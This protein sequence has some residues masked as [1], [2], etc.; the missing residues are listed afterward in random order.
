[1]ASR[2]FVPVV[3]VVGVGPGSARHVYLPLSY[4]IFGSLHTSRIFSYLQAAC[5][6]VAQFMVSVLFSGDDLFCACFRRTRLMLCSWL[7][8]TLFNG[9]WV[10][11]PLWIL[12]EAYRAMNSAISQ[13]EMVDLVHY[14]KKGE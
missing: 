1:V 5:E 7:Y 8:L 10:V 4:A 9:L 14:L 11:F 13:A 2:L 6:G 3:V 12:Y